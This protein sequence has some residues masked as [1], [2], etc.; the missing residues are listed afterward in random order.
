MTSPNILSK[1]KT[2]KDDPVE[3][4]KLLLKLSEDPSLT[5]E[6]RGAANYFSHPDETLNWEQIEQIFEN[7]DL[8]DDIVTDDIV[9]DDIDALIFK[10]PTGFT[11]KLDVKGSQL[12]LND[13]TYTS[14]EEVQRVADD[15]MN[16]LKDPFSVNWVHIAIQKWLNN[17]TFV[18]VACGVDLIKVK[19]MN[20]VV[21][22][23]VFDS[24][25][26]PSEFETTIN[27]LETKVKENFDTL[28]PHWTARGFVD[29]EN[30]HVL[31][32]LFRTFDKT[33]LKNV[34]TLLCA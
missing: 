29:K 2:Y 8:T 33:D 6:Q 4:R 21:I 1:L 3:L 25:I 9:T 7:N 32:V 28:E 22:Y 17:Q 5:S 10:T 11:Y 27:S 13:N 26:E 34:E 15:V 14:F 24:A 23:K 20:Y 30:V 19:T 16:N 31:Y 12:D 18:D